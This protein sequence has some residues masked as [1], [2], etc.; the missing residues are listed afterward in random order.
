ML[1]GEVSDARTMSGIGGRLQFKTLLVLKRNRFAGGA[2]KHRTALVADDI[3]PGRWPPLA[4]SGL[5][6]IEFGPEQREAFSLTPIL[7]YESSPDS[8]D[9]SNITF[10]D[11]QVWPT[12][13]VP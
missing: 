4:N 1:A 7:N 10:E 8:G 13:P 12:V 5:R 11:Q 9:P 2:K 6:K 3:L